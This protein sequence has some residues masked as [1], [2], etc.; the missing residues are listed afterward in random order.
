MASANP[1]IAELSSIMANIPVEGAE[2]ALD[3]DETF[4][5]SFGEESPAQATKLHDELQGALGVLDWAVGLP[6]ARDEDL[7]C[8]AF[9]DRIDAE[10]S[11]SS[12]SLGHDKISCC[13][14]HQT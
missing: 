2:L 10:D 8:V 5:A 7:T 9:F 13:T 1:R 6:T 14:G 4:M 11:H 3:D 12:C